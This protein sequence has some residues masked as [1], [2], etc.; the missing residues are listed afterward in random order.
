VLDGSLAKAPWV[1]SSHLDC[2]LVDV[3]VEQTVWSSRRRDLRLATVAG[4]TR[5][6]KYSVINPRVVF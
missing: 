6:P 4:E 1:H 5:G 2:L 3:F